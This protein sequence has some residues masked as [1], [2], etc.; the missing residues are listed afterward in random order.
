M[1]DKEECEGSEDETAK[2]D[3]GR[4]V[5]IEEL[6]GTRFVIDIDRAHLQ[7]TRFMAEYDIA[8]RQ[9]SEYVNGI[10]NK[11]WPAEEM[12]E[13]I[14]DPAQ[15]IRDEC[16]DVFSKL[17][18]GSDDYQGR[19]FSDLCRMRTYHIDFEKRE[20]GWLD[21]IVRDGKVYAPGFG[22]RP[23]PTTELPASCKDV[24]QIEASQVMIMESEGYPAHG[25]VEVDGVVRWLKP[26]SYES[27]DFDRELPIL[28]QVQQ[29]RQQGSRMRVSNLAGLVLC[30]QTVV[31]M[32][33]DNII[34]SAEGG[35]LLD[36]G[37]WE[38]HDRHAQWE[39]QVR[40]SVEE[41]HSHDIVWGDVNAGNVFIDKE[42]NA[43][44]ID[45]GG[46]NNPDFV[47]DDKRETKEGDWQGVQRMFG[48][49]LPERYA[50]IRQAK[51]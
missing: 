14:R 1:A 32:L 51:G 16:E 40:R 12:W 46:M 2:H 48:E 7:N 15:V 6:R 35:Q 33:L 9:V 19:P 5:R 37:L 20:A 29:L 18:L 11:G 38:L 49:W 31:A 13:S 47:D 30:E 39:S 36:E 34:P 23:L 17:A 24:K 3:D 26:R 45:F 10:V 44:V 27:V 43:W 28:V 41:L 42:Y 22:I 25:K 21:V 50:E 8:T 4:I